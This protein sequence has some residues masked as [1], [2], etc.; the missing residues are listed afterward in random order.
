MKVDDALIEHLSKLACL[1]FSPEEKES[2]R[3]DLE[4]MIGFVEK[5][6]ELDTTGTEPVVQMSSGMNVFRID[7]VGQALPR[8]EA[9]H[10]APDT[11]SSFFKVPKVIKNPLK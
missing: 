2:I 4:D 9:L 10:N 5:L 7:E 3:K 8:E 11:D 1:E 6:K